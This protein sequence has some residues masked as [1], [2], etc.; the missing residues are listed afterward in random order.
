MVGMID[1]RR[2]VTNDVDY[3]WSTAA[4]TDMINNG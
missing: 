3:V 1:F 4:E 2:I